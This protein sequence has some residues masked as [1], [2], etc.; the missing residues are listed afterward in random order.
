MTV[1]D[2]DTDTAFLADVCR[3][4]DEVA[5]KHALDVD[6][7]ARFPH[8]SIDALR[9]AGGLGAFLGPEHGGPGISFAAAPARWS[10]PCIRSR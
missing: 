2:T 4:A 1:T 9:A 6:A 8:E 5:A 10:S 3:I 7:N